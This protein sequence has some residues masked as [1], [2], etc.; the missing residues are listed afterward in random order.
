MTF[1]TWIQEV[2]NLLAHKLGKDITEAYSLIYL[3]EAKLSYI[4]G[5]SPIEYVQSISF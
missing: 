3:S 1:E 4:D 2:A 5:D